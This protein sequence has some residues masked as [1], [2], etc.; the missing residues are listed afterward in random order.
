MVPEN[1][2]D[3]ILSSAIPAIVYL[4]IWIAKYITALLKVKTEQ[5]KANTENEHMKVALDMVS[6]NAIDIVTMLNQTV[7]EGLKAANADGK[8]SSEEAIAIKDQALNMLIA[9]LSEDAKEIISKLYG[10]VDTYLSNLIERVVLQVK[11]K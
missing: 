11:N 6:A 4:L 8:L 7:V 10:D 3:L 1:I 2:K 5:I 9:M